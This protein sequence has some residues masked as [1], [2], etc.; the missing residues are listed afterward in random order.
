MSYKF[1]SK[2][3]PV[4]AFLATVVVLIITLIPILSGLDA[5]N[6]VP[7]PQQSY[8]NEGKIFNTGI[9]LAALLLIIGIITAILFSVLQVVTHPKASMKSL[10]ALGIIAVIFIALYAI[11]DAKGTGSLAQ[12]IERFSLSDTISKIVG[13]GIQLTILLGIGS[14]ILAIFLEVWNY[15][16]N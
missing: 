10:I 16:K 9:Y 1:L 15:F 11:S 12:T 13:A 14:I 5:F 3:G 8:S 7:E 6:S 2:N 4:I